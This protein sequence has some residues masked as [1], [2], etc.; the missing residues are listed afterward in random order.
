LKNKGERK[1]RAREIDSHKEE[2]E[3][4]QGGRNGEGGEEEEEQESV[5]Q[6]Y[7]ATR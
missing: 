7:K 3:A 6:A 2:E 5:N 1:R 4:R